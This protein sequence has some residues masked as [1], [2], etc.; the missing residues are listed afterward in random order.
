MRPWDVARREVQLTTWRAALLAAH[1]N[2]THAA[3]AVGIAYSHAKQL[4]RKYGLTQFAEG[5][6]LQHGGV[7]TVDGRVTGRPRK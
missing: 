6:R 1:G 4:N 7:R 2:I 5:L 3:D